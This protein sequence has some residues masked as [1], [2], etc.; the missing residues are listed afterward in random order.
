MGATVVAVAALG[1]AVLVPRWLASTASGSDVVRIGDRVQGVGSI[2]VVDQAKPRLCIPG[3]GR[4]TPGEAP[5]CSSIGVDLLGLDLATLPGRRTVGATIFSPWVSVMGTWSEAGIEVNGVDAATA[6]GVGLPIASC[7]A[8]A[9]GWP[10]PATS[11]LADEEATQRL[12]SEVSAHPETY[13]GYWSATAIDAAGQVLAVGTT[14]DV[15]AAEATLRNVFPYALCAVRVEFSASDLAGAAMRIA[16]AH[17]DWLAEIDRSAARVRIHVGLLD[18]A[19]YSA[20]SAYREA[21]AD[22]VV[23]RA[24]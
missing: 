9:G 3:I 14:G 8:P 11:R 13:S 4:L 1:V 24:P 21:F 19:T 2:V 6:P 18:D 20:I 10:A 12:A 7:P 16:Q 22:P 15:R 17:P 23:R 5:F